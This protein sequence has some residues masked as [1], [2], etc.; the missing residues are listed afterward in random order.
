VLANGSRLDVTATDLN[1]A[2][3]WKNV[4]SS[5][6]PQEVHEQVGAQRSVHYSTLLCGYTRQG[7]TRQGYTLAHSYALHALP[8]T[9]TAVYAQVLN[10]TFEI[11]DH[12]G[13]ANREGAKCG[14]GAGAD[15]M[16]DW[17]Y[18]RLILMRYQYKARAELEVGG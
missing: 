1:S 6:M 2:G 16:V 4:S 7:Y 5:G 3:E 11:F 15:A 18:R 13:G 17:V 14:P 9:L 10:R 12:Q 8:P